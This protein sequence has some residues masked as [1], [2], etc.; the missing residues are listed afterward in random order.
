MIRSTL[1]NTIASP[2]PTKMRATTAP[3]YAVVRAKPSWASV[4]STA[5]LNSSRCGP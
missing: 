3:A 2:M 1:M 5:P 4:I